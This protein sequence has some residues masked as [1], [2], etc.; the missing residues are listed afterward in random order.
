MK[1]IELDK[2]RMVLERVIKGKDQHTWPVGLDLVASSLQDGVDLVA[3][4]EEKRM[5]T[6][7]SNEKTSKL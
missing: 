3:L 4:R 6:L 2:G 1:T 5:D 7:V